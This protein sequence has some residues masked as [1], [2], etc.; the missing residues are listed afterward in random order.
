VTDAE[1]AA[2]AWAYLTQTTDSYPKWKQ[3]GFPANTNWGK[4]KADLDAIVGGVV[5]PPPP[6]PPPTGTELFNWTG[7]GAQAVAPTYGWDYGFL[8]EGAASSQIIPD[9]LAPG[10]PS[11]RA[12]LPPSASSMH[13]EGQKK[14]TPWTVG[15]RRFFGLQ[16]KLPVGW[17]NP[18]LDGWG[19]NIAQLYYPVCA[20]APFAL[21]LQADHCRLVLLTGQCNPGG[22]VP[23]EYNNGDG[24]AQGPSPRAIIPGRLTL[25]V[26]HT[27][28]AEIKTSYDWTGET[29][30]WHKIEGEANYTKTVEVTGVPTLQYGLC[31][32]GSTWQK[33]STGPDSRGYYVHQKF[34]FYA[35]RANHTRVYDGGNY[36]IADSFDAVASRMA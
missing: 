22:P 10:V 31:N 33:G 24:A 36:R 32:D 14:W 16:F 30:I 19:A 17:Q 11:M 34:G 28:I 5:P 7:T 15:E 18:N 12:T 27:L 26:L 2:R 23:H 29:R 6:P 13:V 9:G 3:R 35:G 25:G 4:A 20:E 21:A 8:K 1:R